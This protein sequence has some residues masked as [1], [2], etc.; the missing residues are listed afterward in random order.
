[1]RKTL[2]AVIFAVVCAVFA[3]VCFALTMAYSAPSEA[4]T[5]SC[6]RDRNWAKLGQAHFTISIINASGVSAPC[7]MGDRDVY[8]EGLGVFH[9]IAGTDTDRQ[10]DIQ[11]GTPFASTFYNATTTPSIAISNSDSLKFD[12]NG[13]AGTT[14]RMKFGTGWDITNTGKIDLLLWKTGRGSPY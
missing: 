10:Y 5:A 11:F 8:N 9:T 3:V 1:M 12:F 7:N 2:Y 4:G 14:F 13:R 6:V